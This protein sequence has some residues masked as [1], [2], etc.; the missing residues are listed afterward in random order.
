MIAR[1]ALTLTVALSA[2]VGATGTTQA[3]TVSFRAEVGSDTRIFPDAPLFGQQSGSRVSPSLLLR[4]ELEWQ[5]NGGAWSVTAEGFARL[6]AHDENRSHV[7]IRE[8]GV[9]YL[10]DSFIAFA[11]LGQVFWGVTEVRHLVDVVNQID[12]V[13][14]LDGED[15]LG[16]PMVAVALEGGWGALDL[17]YLPYFRER[18]L[19]AG[20]ARLR[21]SVPVEAD[22]IYTS[23]Q[24]RWHP[25][26]AAR[27]FRTQG[28][29]DLGLSFFRG[30][31]REPRFQVAAGAEGSP[32]LQP[33][34]DQID[35]VGLDAQWT[36]EGTLL[37]LEA[38]TRAGHGERIYALSGGVEHTL[39]QLLGSDGDLGLIGEVALDSRSEAAPPTLFDQ[40]VFIGG[41]WA[42]NDV[43]DTS[44][45]GGPVVDLESGEVLLLLEAE[46]R[47]GSV[48]R[49]SA[50]VR[51][52]VNTTPG[53]L[54]HGI[55]N[56]GYLSLAITRF[57]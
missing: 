35:Q 19:P 15:K 47:I 32:A 27:A 37:K 2:A 25:G 57:F 51:L 36:G 29:L 48:W 22:G 50:D 6:D 18:T 5:S 11:G 13:E 52:F 7:D 16:Q 41:R 42:W 34:Y 55:R 38:I 1:A 49:A 21:G 44:V 53:S 23:D 17:Y 39:Y 4:P 33:L 54:V 46:R 26:F 20:D 40:D 56:D 24:G 12:G 28:A 31:S 43:S 45:L 8:L 9:Q 14:D 30:T 3:Q 10:G